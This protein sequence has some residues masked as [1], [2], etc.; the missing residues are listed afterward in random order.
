MIH[1]EIENVENKKTEVF[2]MDIIPNIGENI[3][4]PVGRKLVT[5]KIIEKTFIYNKEYVFLNIHL[6]V[7]N[8]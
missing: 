4:Y 7:K 8:I 1:V 3:K 2:I 6:L 5:A